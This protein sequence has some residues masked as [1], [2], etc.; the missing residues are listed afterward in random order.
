MFVS[1][2]LA[3]T[4][5][6]KCETSLVEHFKF[7]SEKIDKNVIQFIGIFSLQ[8]EVKILKHFSPLV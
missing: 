7:L 1:H 2:F 3:E 4:L 8:K 6:E 5:G